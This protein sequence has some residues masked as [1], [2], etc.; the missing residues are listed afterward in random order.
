MEQNGGNPK[1]GDTIVLDLAKFLVGRQ[2]QYRERLVQTEQ[3]TRVLELAIK[4]V[5]KLEGGPLDAREIVR[6]TNRLQVDACR[7][8]LE[9]MARV[10]VIRGVGDGTWGLALPAAQAVKKILSPYI[11]I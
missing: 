8:A 9:A 11:D 10:G 7:E 1:W 3:G 6:K 4:L 5:A 2:V